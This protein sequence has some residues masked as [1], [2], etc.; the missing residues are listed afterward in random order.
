MWI[1][2]LR[3]AHGLPR[4]TYVS[5]ILLPGWF[6]MTGHRAF[7]YLALVSAIA[8]LA[9]SDVTAP[10]TPAIQKSVSPTA[11]VGASFSRYILISGSWVC[12][13]G[14]HVAE[15]ESLHSP[16]LQDLDN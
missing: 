12:V 11:P 8:G 7:R 14:C 4:I 15:P 9:C 2:D 5:Q 1:N 6:T 10:T 13:E 16:I 3:Q